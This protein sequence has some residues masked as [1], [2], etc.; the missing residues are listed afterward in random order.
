MPCQASSATLSSSKKVSQERGADLFWRLCHKTYH[1][2]PK[3]NNPWIVCMHVF[4]PSLVSHIDRKYQMNR[5]ASHCEHKSEKKKAQSQKIETVLHKNSCHCLTSSSC[6]INIQYFYLFTYLIAQGRSLSPSHCT[7]ESLKDG[8]VRRWLESERDPGS[9]TPASDH[10]HSTY[11]LS[12]QARSTH[13]CFF[14]K[15]HR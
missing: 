11:S 5:K 15:E 9:Q 3:S 13:R 12:R 8:E 4:L 10:H 2:E 14:E 6:F 1:H 7:N